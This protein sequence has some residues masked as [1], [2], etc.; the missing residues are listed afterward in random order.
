MSKRL[1]NMNKLVKAA[2][3]E[4]YYVEEDNLYK[5]DGILI[6]KRVGKHGYYEVSMGGRT[7]S[8]PDF[9]RSGVKFHRFVAY[10]KFGDKLF[11]ADCVRH[12]DGNSL[13]NN[14]ENLELGT[15]LQNIM[16]RPPEER[17]AHAQKAANAQKKLSK[18]RLEELRA[19]RASGMIYKDLCK[20]YGI[21]QSTLSYI[22]NGKTYKTA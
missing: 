8:L 5:S 3:E 9:K 1:S 15:V 12:L 13:N 7:S 19:D 2:F 21:A 20:K 14:P 16:D 17:R 22:L 11:D 18:E 4:G 10:Q 6:K